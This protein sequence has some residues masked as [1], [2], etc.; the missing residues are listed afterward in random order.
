MLEGKE[1]PFVMTENR[2]LWRMV[3]KKVAFKF[4]PKK[5]HE[6]MRALIRAGADTH[7]LVYAGDSSLKRRLRVMKNHLGNIKR[8]DQYN[9]V[10]QD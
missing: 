6:E 10:P 9:K 4:T 2:S 1:L 5:Y 7:S 3:P 8:F